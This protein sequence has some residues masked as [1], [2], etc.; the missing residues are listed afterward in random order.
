M[1]VHHFDRDSRV[2]NYTFEQLFGTI[3]KELVQYTAIEVFKKPENLGII[4]SIRWAKQNA[5]PINHITGDVNYLALGLPTKNTIITVHDL[6]H[7]LRGLNGL[8]KIVYKK[9]WMDLPFSKAAHLTAISEFTKSQ[10]MEFAGIPESKISVIKNPVL[11]FI[12]HSDLKYHEVPVILQVGSGTNKNLER[13]ILAIRGLDVKLLL[14][15]RLDNPHHVQMLRDY[16]INYEQRI[17]LNQEGLN[18]AYR[19][20]DFLFFASEYEGF[21]MPILEA[22]A[23]GRPVITGN[24]SAMPEASGEGA[25][26]VDPFNV[27]EIRHAII[28]L[29]EDRSLREELVLKGKENLKLY[30]LE[31][32][33]KAYFKLYEE[34]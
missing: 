2:G 27:E 25:L 29:M 6:G 8:K 16:G 18:Q 21:G 3:R 10:L 26:I 23:A 24:V 4:Q 11:P 32:I 13:L 20:C 5:G 14:L 33:A 12:K 17:D 22:Q 15:N 34:I 9:L 31:P 30:Q 1:L 19:D 7:Y 28:Q